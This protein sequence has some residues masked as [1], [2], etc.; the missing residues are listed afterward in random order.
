MH[1]HWAS[2]EFYRE[3]EE[4]RKSEKLA[5]EKRKQLQERKDKF[6]AQLAEEKRQFELELKGDYTS[7]YFHQNHSSRKLSLYFRAQ[8]TKIQTNAK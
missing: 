1:E 7:F 3:V 4:K 6:R 8:K 5:E 2:P